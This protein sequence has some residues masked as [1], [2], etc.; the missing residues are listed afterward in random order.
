[1]HLSFFFNYSVDATN[2]DGHPGRL[3]NHSKTS[4]NVVTKLVEIRGVPHL[5]FF[6]SKLVDIGE[7][8]VYDYGDRRKIAI[9]DNKWLAT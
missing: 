3:L 7:E 4:P 9:E 6:A 1:M 2:D 8:L 5:C